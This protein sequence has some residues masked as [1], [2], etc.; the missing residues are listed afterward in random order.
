MKLESLEAIVSALNK[1]NV[2]YLI[3]GGVAV[4]AHGYGRLTWDIDLVLDL[5][6]KNVRRAVGALESLSYQPVPPVSAIDFADPV[7]RETWIKE[8][9]MVV[10]SLRSEKHRDTPIDLFVS[11]P[12]DFNIEYRRSMVGDL[13]P[14]LQARFV[15]LETLIRMK[16]AASREKDL[17][18]VRQLKILL[19]ESDEEA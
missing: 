7:I 18:D 5:E 2:R 14:D 17:E 12:F 1:E 4:N 16:E 11:E 19:E 3:A 6:G 10:F 8:K 13:R 9:S 15:C